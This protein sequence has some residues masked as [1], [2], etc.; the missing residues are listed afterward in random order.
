[1]LDDDDAEKKGMFIHAVQQT[2]GFLPEN[3]QIDSNSTNGTK[4]KKKTREEA[5]RLMAKF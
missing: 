4:K 3:E 2:I 5:N 1:M